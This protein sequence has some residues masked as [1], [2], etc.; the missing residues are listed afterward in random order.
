MHTLLIECKLASN[1]I[2]DYLSYA[3]NIYQVSLRSGN[4]SVYLYDR[5]YITLQVSHGLRWGADIR[6]YGSPLVPWEITFFA[7]Y[8]FTLYG[9]RQ[10]IIWR[11]PNNYMASAK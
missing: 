3:T 4:G 5:E 7:P 9:V 8:G 11:P 10:I 1:A 6:T 2:M